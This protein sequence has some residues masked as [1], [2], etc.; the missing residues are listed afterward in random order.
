MPSSKTNQSRRKTTGKKANGPRRPRWRRWLGRVLLVVVPAAMVAGG[1]YVYW[2]DRWVTREFEGKRWSIPARVYARPLELYPNRQ[3]SPANLQRE[4]QAAGYRHVDSVDE[5]GEYSRSG[6]R[7]HLHTRTFRF[8]DG[9]EPG[10]PLAL[11][12][13]GERVAA[14]RHAGTGDSVSLV[15]VDPA[16]I[17][18]IQPNH[19]EDRRLVR[20]DEDVP[21]PLVE[22]LI[23]VEDQG[24]ADHFGIDP[25][26]IIRAAWANLKAGEVVQGGST[27][28]Q[29][30]VKNF[31]LTP[32][33]TLGRK[34]NEALMAML[35]EVHYDKATILQAYLN[36]VYLGQDGERAIHGFGL[37]SQFYFGRPLDELQLAQQALLVGLAKG[38]S[39]YDPREHPERARQ[40][41]ATVLA[42]M[43]EQ[44]FIEPA[45]ARAAKGKPL[46]VTRR[47]GDETLPH[48]GFMDLVRRHLQRDYDRQDL[49]RDG[50]R[51]FTTLAP[52]VQQAAE[53]AVQQRLSRWHD[54]MEAA[55]V[56]VDVD[57][58]EV[59][60][61]VGGRDVRYAGF[62]RALDMR[63]PMGSLIKPAVYLTALSRPSHYGL[64][65]PIEDRPI[66]L[67]DDQGDKWQ[68]GNY[69]DKYLGR[70]PLW[71]GLADSRNAA[72][73]RL[74]LD[75]GLRAVVATLDRL[76]ARVP[77]TIYPSILLGAADQ[78]PLDIARFYESLATG[79]FRTPLRSVRAVT[80]GEGEVVSRYQLEM[81]RAADPGPV[82]LVNHGLQR[83]VSRG[84]A[85][86]LERW[87]AGD[88][89]VAGK[90]GTTNDR[91]DSW[92][93]GFTGDRLGV[94]WVGRDDN[95]RTGLTG[96]TGAMTVWGEMF[97]GLSLRPLADEPPAS[98]E[99]LWVDRDS[100]QRT[101]EGCRGAVQLPY[102]EDSAP[103][104]RNECAQG[105][106]DEGWFDR[107]FQ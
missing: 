65:T 54:A 94:V 44:G 61:V 36:E 82:Y 75:L 29:Q 12:F 8:P 98:V 90:T 4:L 100:G 71:R 87:V 23:A 9:R 73:V 39:R 95:G 41:R 99:T 49:A 102:I 1:G 35:L 13:E 10:R 57:N 30:L 19:Q 38:P 53:R 48:P 33:Q 74:G 3:L 104:G 46:G 50:L 91:R 69:D 34:I 93:A 72:T 84:T 31:Y 42:V 101:A 55:V 78:S 22:A 21:R 45:E 85:A 7:F 43:A 77:D 86:G 52:H 26:G 79:G 27:L 96:S 28:T 66:T 32:K 24:F 18:R 5:P 106:D 51:V 76:G 59:E 89:R 15:R 17:G 63:R 88:R 20:L 81:D 60:A 83:V 67:Q 97:Q 25:A 16:T 56:S 40:R 6:S 64:G 103:Q 58:G 107:W 68:P 2:L 92:F 37:A 70:I 14:L 47:P 62:N 105:T 80:T 11:R